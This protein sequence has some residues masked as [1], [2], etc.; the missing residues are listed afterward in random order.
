MLIH[1]VTAID[2]IQKLN[3]IYIAFY[4]SFYILGL[5]QLFRQS[6][7][8]T[9]GPGHEVELFQTCARVES[10]AIKSNFEQE[11]VALDGNFL[12]NTTKENEGF[13]VCNNGTFVVQLIHMMIGY[14]CMQLNGIL[15]IK[16]ILG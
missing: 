5:V 9:Y 14:L 15:I 7:R 4:F 13:Y 10:F 3:L 11:T 2:Y 8:V 12:V 6:E 16:S 1:N